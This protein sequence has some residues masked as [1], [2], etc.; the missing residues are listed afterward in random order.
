MSLSPGRVFLVARNPEPDSKLP[1]LLW[2]PVDR[3]LVRCCIGRPG[4]TVALAEARARWTDTLGCGI[5]SRGPV[6]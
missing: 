4:G 3:G 2:L 6:R 1:Y 5:R